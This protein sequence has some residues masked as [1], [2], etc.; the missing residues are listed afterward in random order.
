[1]AGPVTGYLDPDAL[2]GSLLSPVISLSVAVILFEGGLSLSIRELREIGGIVRNLVTLGV[3]IT[4]IIAGGT[5]YLILGL[6]VPLALLFGAILVVTGPTVIVPLLRHIRPEERVG[7]AMKWE[8]I[9]NDP[10]GAI[11]AV[12]VFEAIL[13]G[14]FTGRLDFAAV[15]KF[16]SSVG[17]GTLCGII[18]AALFVLLLYFH[19]VPDFLQNA[20]SLMMVVATFTLSNSFKA[21][22]GLL[23]VTVMGIA[24]ANQ[25]RYPVQHIIEFKENLRVLI[26]AGLF[27]VLGAR[28]K[29]SDL[30]AIG[31]ATFLFFAILVFVARPL[32][33]EAS[34]V[35]SKLKKQEKLFLMWMAPRGIVAAAVAS[36]FAAR[37]VESGYAQAA[38]LVPYTFFV[39]IGTVALYGLTAFPVARG[40]GVAEGSPQGVLIVGAHSWAR[41]M[42]KALKAEGF[43][44]V[45]VDSNWANVRETR[46]A[47]LPA[48]YGGIVSE[49]VLDEI[50]LYGVGRLLALTPNDEANALAAVHFG[51]VFGRKEVYQ[52]TPVRGE[53]GDRKTLSPK[54]LSGRFLFT[55]ECTY[56]HLSQKFGEGYS[57]KATSLTDKFDYAAFRSRYGAA[58]T[59]LFVVDTAGNLQVFAQDTQRKPRS[60]QT[61]ISLIPPQPEEH[62]EKAVSEEAPVKS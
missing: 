54:H 35:G 50:D 24:M 34:T 26:I 51:D 3:L 55:K 18:G 53:S 9:L 38:L 30:E 29:V 57:L 32:A 5:A 36:I 33:V 42:A 20:F 59:P 19:W 21:E 28:L 60:G 15:G 31:P 48:Y 16:L 7:N 43:R 37:L 11:L 40:L 17:V 6:D 23:A 14:S 47:G 56:S 52:L 10:I 25:K 8:G 12:L 4:W 62:T 22:S 61:L 13:A 49:S 2:F 27:I 1:V 41:E 39:I 45:L 44:A 58:S 46:M